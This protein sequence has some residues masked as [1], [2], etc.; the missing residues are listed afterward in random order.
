MSTSQHSSSH[1][2]H[3]HHKHR[4]SSLRKESI[5]FDANIGVSPPPIPIIKKGSIKKVRKH[6]AKK[7]GD[8]KC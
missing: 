3:H 6:K 5:T 4:Q 7:F 2:R 1:H 8:D